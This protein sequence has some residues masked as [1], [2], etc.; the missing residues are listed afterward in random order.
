MDHQDYRN[1]PIKFLD[2]GGDCDDR[3]DHMETRLKVTLMVQYDTQSSHLFFR[4]T[5]PSGCH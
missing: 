4:G 2:N 1:R 5:L 3:D